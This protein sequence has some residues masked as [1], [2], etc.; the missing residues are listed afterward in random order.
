MTS[1]ATRG[2]SSISL[3]K[4]E[5]K[6]YSIARAINAM[7]DNGGFL[8]DSLEKD[9]SDEIAKGDGRSARGFFVPPQVLRTMK[10]GTDPFGGYAV[11][12]GNVADTMLDLLR[13]VSAPGRLGVTMVDGNAQMRMPLAHADVPTMAGQNFQIPRLDADP[14]TYFLDEDEAVTD[15]LN[16]SMGALRVDPH[17]VASALPVT[18]RLLRQSVPATDTLLAASV[19]KACANSIDEAFLVGTGVDGQPVGVLNTT[20]VTTTATTL[21]HANVAAMLKRLQESNID[22]LNVR[23]LS[24]GAGRES[25]ATTEKVANTGVFLLSDGPGEGTVENRAYVSSE[26]VPASQ[27][28]AGDWSHAMLTLWGA[29]DI[30]IDGNTLA[31]RDGVV[32]RVFQDHDVT[33]LRPSAFQVLDF[34]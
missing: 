2:P 34:S 25:L 28:V 7:A 10:V 31:A 13:P 6:G 24:N 16:M 26:H 8:P 3:S 14:S 1:T 22:P 17:T 23:F 9:I 20:G 30:Y 5:R 18:R 12:T 32:I 27:L 33:V 15:D 11:P 21:T 19:V 29:P 4:R